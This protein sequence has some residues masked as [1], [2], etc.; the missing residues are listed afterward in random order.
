MKRARILAVCAA[1]AALGARAARAGE[2]VVV[3]PEAPMPPYQ[4]ALQGICD[5]LGACPL[6]LLA[7]RKLEIPSDARVV[8]A[9]GGRAAR[10]R[11]PA[12]IALITALAPGYD[13]RSGGTVVHVR[14]T[15]SPEEFARRLRKLLPDARRAVLLW[16]EPLSGAFAREVRAAAAP[17]GLEALPVELADADELPVAL[18]GLPAADAI[19]LSPDPGLVT[20]TTFDAVREYAR[21]RGAVFYAPA[22]G[23]AARG[24]DAGLA[25][26]FREAGFRAGA[27]AREVLSAK[28]SPREEYPDEPVE[29]PKSLPLVSTRTL[30]QTPR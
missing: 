27:A 13:A 29:E 16:S 20:A 14:L 28:G 8:I 17:L 1:L 2:I 5:A 7:N 10:L 12:R 11:Y 9:V 6:V 23:L 30:V 18:R 25:P 24:A 22:P 21:T 4:E 15:Y 3:T 26:S 19:W